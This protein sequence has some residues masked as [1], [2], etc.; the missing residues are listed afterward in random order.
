MGP[1]LR[2][3]GMLTWDNVWMCCCNL[4]DN[5]QRH[6]QTFLPLKPTTQFNDRNEILHPLQNYQSSRTC[7]AFYSCSRKRIID[8]ALSSCARVRT[9]P[10]RR[11]LRRHGR[12]T[13]MV[14]SLS[15]SFVRTIHDKGLRESVQPGLSI[16]APVGVDLF[17]M[18]T[19]MAL[20]YYH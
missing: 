8:C 2:L 7:V 9:L 19:T 16:H 15:R 18:Y 4:R 13:S 5:N 14:S 11:S 10:H 1:F 20:L 3:R 17:S 6:M 12:F